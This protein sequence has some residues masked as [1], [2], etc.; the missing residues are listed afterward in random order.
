MDQQKSI[1][2]SLAKIEKRNQRLLSLYEEELI[3]KEEF[4]KERLSLD[5]EKKFLEVELNEANQRIF[6]NDLNNFDLQ[7]TLSSIHNLAE[8]FEDLD[9]QE[10]RELLRTIISKIGVGKHQLDCHFFAIPKSFVDWS[11]TDKGS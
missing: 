11:H 5:S 6:S 9:F 2:Q 8:V 10:R 7:A 1:Q 3:Q 4:V